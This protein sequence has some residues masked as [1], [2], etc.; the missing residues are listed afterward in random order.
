MTKPRSWRDCIA[1]HPAAELFPLMSEPELRELGEDIKAHGLRE[2]ASMLDGELIDGRNRL[3]A[4]ELV[5]IK[6]VSNGQFDW[7]NIPFRNIQG[8]DPVTFVISKNLHRR[9]LTAD[10]KRELVE[11]LL[12]ATPDKSNR[13]IAETVKVVSH[14][15]VGAWRAEL[16]GRGKIY[17]VETRTDTK[18]RR[19]Q[20]HKPR[21]TSRKFPASPAVTAAADRAEARAQAPTPAPQ[22]EPSQIDP[23]LDKLRADLA[24]EKMV[25]D[26]ALLG[27]RH[28]LEAHD[29]Y[30]TRKQ[31]ADVLFCLHPDTYNQ[32]DPERRKKAWR[33][34]Y[35][36]D[37][38]MSGL[39][40]KARKSVIVTTIYRDGT[41][42]LWPI[43]SPNPGE[44]DNQA[45]STA[46]MA[47]KLAMDHWVSLV[48]KARSYATRQALEGYAPEPDW[49]AVPPFEDLITLA[50][51]NDGIIRNKTHHIYTEQIGAPSKSDDDAGDL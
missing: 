23:E 7:A 40:D 37:K 50:F 15:T 31:F 28:A 49:S 42:R 18:G 47:A 22:P 25:R 21:T 19:Q 17:H 11:K 4:M 32:A 34:I 9:H 6:L 2:G 26:Q 35:L 20:A 39:I 30:W 10:Q 14:V 44:K 13:Q 24:H 3:D 27:W 51:G 41:V 38:P 1:I 33:L 29:G 46:R 48:W 36:V 45:W 8:V 12:T 43:P 5:G 16:E